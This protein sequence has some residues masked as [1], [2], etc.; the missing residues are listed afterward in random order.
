MEK[1]SSA[2]AD[3]VAASGMTERKVEAVLKA[4]RVAVEPQQ[5]LC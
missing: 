5:Q 2:V 4:V 1:F 3:V